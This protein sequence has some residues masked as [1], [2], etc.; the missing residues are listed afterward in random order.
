MANFLACRLTKTGPVEQKGTVGIRPNQFFQ[1]KLTL[2]QPEGQIMAHHIGMSQP[3]V[4]AGPAKAGILL[5]FLSFSLR[6]VQNAIWPR[7]PYAYHTYNWLEVG[8][9]KKL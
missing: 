7:I 1:A 2:F 4:S 6:T 8:G 9:Q 5:L 3:N